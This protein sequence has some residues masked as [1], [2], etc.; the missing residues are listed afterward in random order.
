MVMGGFGGEV[1]V[2]AE[3]KRVC[4]G[5]EQM[6]L[7]LVLIHVNSIGKKSIFQT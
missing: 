2:A 4:N 1:K 3:G 5:K 7:R 6:I